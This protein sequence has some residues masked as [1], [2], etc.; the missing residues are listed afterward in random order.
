MITFISG[1]VSRRY[2]AKSSILYV[3]YY[4]YRKTNVIFSFVIFSYVMKSSLLVTFYV[5]FA[6][7]PHVPKVK[8]PIEVAMDN[9]VFFFLTFLVALLAILWE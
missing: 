6:A 1:N 3:M 9:I 5:M 7:Q 2:S 8:V 4:M